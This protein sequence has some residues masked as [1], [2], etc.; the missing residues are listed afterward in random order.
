MARMIP[1][2]VA[3]ETPRGERQLYEKLKND[4]ET[5]GWVIFHSFDIR[6]HTVR[7]AGEADILIFIPNLGVLCVEVKGCDVSRNEGLW[8]YHYAQP[9][10]TSLSP[11]RQASDAAHSIRNF[12]ISKDATLSNIFFYSLVVF[13]EIDFNEP[14]LEWDPWQV[15]CRTDLLRL[16][17]S[18]LM[19]HSLEKG[20]QKL[21]N[22]NLQNENNSKNNFT[23][24]LQV[25]SII[26]LLRGDFEYISAGKNSIEAF[27]INIKKFTEEQFVSLDHIEDNPR[28]IFKGPAGTGKT[29]LAIESAK[30]SV[31]NGQSVALFC[32]NSILSNWFRRETKHI[33]L[34]AES[35]GINFYA[36]SFSSFML[37]ASGLT[38]PDNSGD[39]F[40]DKE[41]PLK[42]IDSLLLSNKNPLN[43]FDFIIVDEAQDLLFDEYLD[44]MDLILKGGMSGG[45]WVLFGDYERQSI[46]ADP[47]GVQGQNLLQSRVGTSFSTFRLRINCRNSP[48][49]ADAVTITTGMHP[50]YSR[51]LNQEDSIDVDTI[52]FKNIEHERE[53]LSNILIKLLKTFNA[54]QIVILSVKK[55]SDSCCANFQFG[56]NNIQL[57]PLRGGS[58]K[59]N[60]IIY[61]SS[62]YSFKGMEA[63]V[64]ILTDVDRLNDDHSKSLLY[65]GMSRARLQLHILLDEKLR[66][67][68]GKLLDEGLKSALNEN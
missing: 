62:V 8:T 3:S 1:P 41:L 54:S 36:G 45:R 44:I 67:P 37:K 32:Y 51:V 4:P 10:V 6:R 9:K 24:K 46:Y 53:L 19:I 43:Q 11:F 60:S 57:V 59:I 56:D 66:S 28:V 63:P 14:S 48:R 15:I 47:G 42:T 61:Y 2:Y 12:L 5:K 68:Y 33:A 35:S 25:D 27:E 26:K 20:L 50:G 39:N 22:N 58:E 49:I 64:I 29:F 40:W 38:V 30:R 13:T 52:F 31:L 23:N 18:K 55:D 65:V 16:P 17:I 21:K 34:D 7:S